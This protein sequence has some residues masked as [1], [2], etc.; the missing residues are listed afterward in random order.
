MFKDRPT[1]RQPVRE[2]RW[3]SPDANVEAALNEVAESLHDNP[4]SPDRK[5]ASIIADHVTVLKD[6]QS[7]LLEQINQLKTLLSLV[8]EELRQSVV[9]SAALKAAI[10]QME[11]QYEPPVDET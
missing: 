11:G 10:E 2:D 6:K 1:K 5:P 4:L 7:A 9:A 3:A 8:T